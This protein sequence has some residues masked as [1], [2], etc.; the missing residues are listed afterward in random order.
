MIID[1]YTD[2][3]CI[4]NPGP[5]GWAY[6]VPSTDVLKGGGCENTT[7]NRM[8]LSAV[9]NALQDYRNDDIHIHSDSMYVIN[10]STIWKDMWLNRNMFK[11]KN[12]NLWLN[13]YKLQT[14]RVVRFSY[15]K[16]H[17]KGGS[18]EN[19]NNNK[20]DAHAN[21]YSKQFCK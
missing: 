15:V 4:F 21:E 16:G 11:V 12:K 14:G 8:E 6:Y 18:I 7:N 5:G 13:L 19:E 1:I 20:V 9:I 10:G 2:G 3:S 17:V